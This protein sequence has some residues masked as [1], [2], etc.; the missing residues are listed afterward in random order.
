LI[1]SSHY[2][3]SINYSEE[4][5]IEAKSGI[6]RFY[7]TLKNYPNSAV[8]NVADLE[9]SSHYQRFIEAMNDDFNT[10]VALAVM[11][12]LVK[13]INALDSAL[14]NKKSSTEVLVA[15]LKFMANVLGILQTD[16][17]EYLQCRGESSDLS[18][19]DIEAMITARQQAKKDKNYTLADEIRS[20]LIHQGIVLEDSREGTSWRKK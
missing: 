13:E 10:R 14:A 9:K 1:V 5:L 11:Y 20:E 16:P 4:N 15:E 17:T 3:S 2:R 12:D 19:A 6:D 8:A 18:P 7:H